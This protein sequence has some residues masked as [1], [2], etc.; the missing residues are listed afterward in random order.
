MATYTM[1]QIDWVVEFDDW[2][3]KEAKD[4]DTVFAHTGAQKLLAK[5]RATR[6][7]PEISIDVELVTD[8][9]QATRT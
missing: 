1:K 2:V 7:K 3:T 4:G 8:K 6:L 9:S 5:P